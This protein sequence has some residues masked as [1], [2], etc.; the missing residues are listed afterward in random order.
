MPFLYVNVFFHVAFHSSILHGYSAVGI[1]AVYV[2]QFCDILD[3]FVI[4]P[5]LFMLYSI[6]FCILFHFLR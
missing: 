5:A 6:D 2:L 1:V 3:E 4:V